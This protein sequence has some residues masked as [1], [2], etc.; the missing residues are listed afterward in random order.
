MTV[1]DS[2][3]DA[4]E[5]LSGRLFMDALGGFHLLTVYLGHR[6][7][8]FRALAD[9]PETSVDELAAAAA[10][11]ARYVREWVQAEVIAGLIQASD[12]DLTVATL[13]LSPGVVEVLVTETHPEYL[14][15]LGYALAS[16]G[17]VLPDL[18][19][20]FRTGAGVPYEAYGDDGIEAQS[21]LNRPAFVN[22]LASHW[23]PAIPGVD[24]RLRDA[25]RPARVADV[26]SGVG[27]AAIEL[28]RAFPNARVDGIDL[29][30]RSIAAAKA[31]SIEAGVA[32]RAL[33]R[34]ADAARGG[35][36]SGRY[37]LV[38]FLESL[39]DMAHPVDALAAAR[40][41]VVDGGAVVVMDERAGV[42][43]PAAGDP[44]ETFFG[45][46]STLWCLPQARVDPESESPGTVM[47]PQVL[48]S[49]ARRAG[50]AGIETL[51][52]DHPF[53]RFYRLAA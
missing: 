29:D 11:D 46:I 27:W 53:W 22:D 21:A 13:R 42:V 14:A 6:L 49:I 24:E 20:A 40:T 9:R 25:S 45:T 2:P 18:V 7:G 15:G 23:I 37:D 33:F 30:T 17:R 50:W 12:E 8:L 4:A 10:L 16:V 34:V 38:L 1:V 26:G 32:D 51:P 28:A 43:R 35:L 5:E 41:A 31:N 44:I 47:R 48:E 52:I 36:A 3:L 39:H 19:G